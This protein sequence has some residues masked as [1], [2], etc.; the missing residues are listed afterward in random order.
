MTRP[1]ARCLYLFAK[2][3]IAT[4][5]AC[6]T[7][8]TQAWP[9]PVVG[10]AI[11]AA[12][13][14]VSVLDGLPGS[15]LTFGATSAGPTLSTPTMF[16]NNA[17]GAATVSGTVTYGQIDA[18]A[19]VS[20]PN[21]GD[22]A[23]AGFGG[24]WQDSLTVTSATLAA[25]TPVEVQGTLTYD[26]GSSCAG[27][28][29]DQVQEIVAFNLGAPQISASEATCGTPLIGMQTVDVAT[30]VGATLQLDGQV[31][32][33]AAVSQNSSAVVDPPTGFFVDPL[34]PGVS[35]VTG[36]GVSYLTPPLLCPSL[37]PSPC[38]ASHSPASRTVGVGRRPD[39]RDKGGDRTARRGRLRLTNAMN[40]RSA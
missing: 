28:Y 27:P 14:Q 10:L 25:G 26:F 31:Y 4:G 2:V 30:Y 5:V 22:Y 36:S 23:T 38:S 11:S 16:V 7:V 3:A 18:S 19:S 34:T 39:R 9:T 13:T 15:T 8:P 40:S 29:I 6:L 21:G 32:V 12:D 24:I 35:Y 17:G 20:S 33:F 37:A 1:I